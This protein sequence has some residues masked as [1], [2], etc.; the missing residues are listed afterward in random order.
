MYAQPDRLPGFVAGVCPG[1]N[2]VPPACDINATLAMSIHEICFS[3]SV[4][5]ESKS[6]GSFQLN[7]ARAIQVSWVVGVRGH[8]SSRRG[9]LG[10]RFA[11]AMR[12][13]SAMASLNVTKL[14]AT[15][16]RR[17]ALEQ[18]IEG[19]PPVAKRQSR[20]WRKLIGKFQVLFA[21]SHESNFSHGHNLKCVDG[22]PHHRQESP[23]RPHPNPIE[24]PLFRTAVWNQGLLR[25]RDRC[26]ARYRCK[27]RPVPRICIRRVSYAGGGF[28]GCAMV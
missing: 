5:R 27:D 22:N 1:N 10:D 16:L 3:S 12:T 13:D 14:S 18:R 8:I 23:S 6:S 7:L 11:Q 9:E 20:H 21:T 26:K 19:D 25:H 17:H 2:R 15:T 4:K 24:G 28:E